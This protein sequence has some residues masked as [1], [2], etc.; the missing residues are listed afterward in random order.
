MTNTGL[1]CMLVASKCDI[2]QDSRQ[3]SPHFH[4]QVRR[5]LASVAIAEVSMKT[6]QTIKLCFLN[7]LNRLSAAPRGMS[8]PW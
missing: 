1:P 8:I 7:M 4:E 6:P 5:N 2:K 3:I